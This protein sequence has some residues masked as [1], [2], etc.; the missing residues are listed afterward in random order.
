MGSN[1]SEKDVRKFLSK[2]NVLVADDS[3]FDRE[4]IVA[5]LRAI[6]IRKIQMAE[7]GSIA[8]GKIENAVAIRM[9]F[10]IIFTDWKMPAQ[11]GYSLLRWIRRDPHMQKLAIIMTTGASNEDDVEEF[12]EHGANDVIVKPV[13]AETLKKKILNLYG[14]SKLEAA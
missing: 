12:F 3:E 5:H 14:I 4:L 11:D 9:P 13:N 2:L 6:G 7:N 8:A 10:H 1:M